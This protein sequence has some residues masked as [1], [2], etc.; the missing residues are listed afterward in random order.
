[1]LGYRYEEKGRGSMGAVIRSE[2]GTKMGMVPWG[3]EGE[4]I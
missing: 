2:S 4:D 1:L 3:R